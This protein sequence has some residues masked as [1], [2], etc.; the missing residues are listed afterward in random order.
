MIVTL[1]NH[2]VGA[3]RHVAG[4]AGE[5]RI[6]PGMVAVI[7]ARIF[8][9]VAQ[10]G[11]FGGWSLYLK[12]G[13]PTYTYDY[14]GLKQSK[15]A[16]PDALAAGKATIRYD[17]AYDGGG[18]GKGGTGTLFVNDK[19]V[20]TGRI[21]ETQCCV[22]SADEGAD[23]GSDNETNVTDDYK[24]GDNKFTGKI[25]K[26]TVQLKPSDAAAATAAEKAA[27]EGAQ[28]GAESIE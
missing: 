11:R 4:G 3:D 19:L 17:F 14:L 21:E 26:V 10:A 16:A 2:H 9:G 24:E 20:A 25:A 1:V 28:K 18:V 8:G 22:F 15:I 23:V 27:E 12:D 7:D 13:N 5:R 6:D